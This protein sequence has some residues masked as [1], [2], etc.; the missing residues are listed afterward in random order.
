MGWVFFILVILVVL[1]EFVGV[2]FLGYLLFGEVF[3]LIIL[4]GVVILLIGV[5]VVVLS[6]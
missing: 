4:L 3:F 5:V 2:S 1:F 6:F